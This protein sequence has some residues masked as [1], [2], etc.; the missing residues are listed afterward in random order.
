M[1]YYSGF[2]RR[3]QGPELGE[4]LLDAGLTHNGVT[5]EFSPFLSLENGSLQLIGDP[6]LDL[7]KSA[8]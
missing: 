7:T 1:Y 6:G 3:C 5:V 2:L 4:N 8:E